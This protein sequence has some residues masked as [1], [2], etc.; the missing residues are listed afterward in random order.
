VAVKKVYIVCDIEGVAGVVFYEHRHSGMTPLNYEILKRNR[1]LM[2][3][4]A[5][6]AVRGSFNAG[7]EVVLVHDH[8]GAGYNILPELLQPRAELIHGRNEQGYSFGLFHPGL[9]ESFDAL[10]VLGMH[11]KAGTVNGCTPHSMIHVSTEAGEEYKLS[12]AA[13]SMAWAGGFKVPSVFISGDR[14]AVEDA[15]RHCPGMGYN[16][17]KTHYASQLARTVSPETSR[18]G[19]ESGVKES[20]K[21]ISAVEPFVIE[22]PCRVQVS[23]R[24]P[25]ARWPEKP[26]EHPD[27]QTALIKTMTSL[28]WYKPVSEIDDGWRYPDRTHPSPMPGDKWNM[29]NFKV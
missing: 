12:E 6:A 19:I 2:T 16:I 10:I 21:N 18:S 14:A 15:R 1:V 3:E 11:A 4:E 23:D 13:N 26:E 25:E 8:H 20:L 7:A 29:R 17:S 5:N 24:N 28:P 9:D 27:F 22:G